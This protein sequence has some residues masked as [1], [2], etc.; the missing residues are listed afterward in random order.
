MID[1][2]V[3]VFPDKIAEGAIAKLAVAAK[4]VPS[5]NGTFSD[6]V[7]KMKIW[8]V[9]EFWLMPIATNEKQMTNVNDFALSCKSDACYPFASVYPL[10]NKAIDELERVYGLGFKGVKLHPEYQQFEVSDK[11][12]YPVYDFIKSHGMMLCFHAGK[13]CAYPNTYYASPKSIAKVADDFKEIKIIAA[14][15]G[16]W[17]V[18]QE[19]LEYEAGKDIYFDT[20]YLKGM[21]SDDEVKKILNHH[22]KE[23][24]LLGS[25][26]PWSSPINERE[27]F[28]KFLSPN[29]IELIC[30][31]NAT[32]LKSEAERG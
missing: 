11:R 17:N 8:G 18:W 7:N 23:R 20:A 26:C 27:Y 5:T 1:T 24:I 25:D 32:D 4:K 16:G 19:V 10:S 6:T 30:D 28:E 22:S 15:L 13:D 2:H 31:K 9:D 21:I 12:V 3:H 29:E 14:H